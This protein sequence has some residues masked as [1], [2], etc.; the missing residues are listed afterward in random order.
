MV[1]PQP[2]DINSPFISFVNQSSGH[3][4]SIWTG[5]NLLDSNNIASY[6]SDTLN[7]NS[8]F[9]HEFEA[10]ADTHYIL[11][12]VISD[13]GCTARDSSFIIIDPSFTLFVPDAFTPDNDLHNDYFLPIINGIQEYTLNIYDRSGNRIFET[14]EYI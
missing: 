4:T 7:T 9:I 10:V 8:T 14:N 2:T 11:L 13:S 5:Y 12:E 6:W 3:I 1:Y